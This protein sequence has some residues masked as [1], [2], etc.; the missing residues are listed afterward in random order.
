M[1]RYYVAL[2]W[3]KLCTFVAQGK[4]SRDSGAQPGRLDNWHRPGRRNSGLSKE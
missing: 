4:F 3:K 1:F 2:N